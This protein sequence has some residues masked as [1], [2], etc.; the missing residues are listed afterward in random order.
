L[1]QSFCY[2]VVREIIYHLIKIYPHH[3]DIKQIEFNK[4][5]NYLKIH[6]RATKQEIARIIGKGFRATYNKLIELEKKKIVKRN[7]KKVGAPTYWSLF[8]HDG[9]NSCL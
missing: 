3:L 2:D 1:K 6:Y 9:T 7:R 4:I 8:F 5:I